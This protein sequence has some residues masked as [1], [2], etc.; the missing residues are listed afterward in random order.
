MARILIIENSPFFADVLACTLGLEKHDV[1]V[2]NTAAEGIR[3][4][5]A[6]RPD[7]VVA[8][9]SLRGG[10]HG[11]EVCRRIR[12]ASPGTKAVI[13]TGHD[14]LVS[15]AREYCR[16]GVA[17]LVKPFHREDILA[18]VCRALR[19]DAIIPPIHLVAADS[20]DVAAN[21]ILISR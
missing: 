17:V 19:G 2:A 11:G 12:A 4:G 5:L 16:S 14:E 1:V 9:W 21:S 15:Q 6:S 7:L 18:A 8:A 20:P 3:L 10:M 13:I